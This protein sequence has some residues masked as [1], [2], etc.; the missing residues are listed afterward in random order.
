MKHPTYSSSN[1]SIPF[2]YLAPISHPFSSI[3]N[4]SFMHIAQNLH[5]QDFSYNWCLLRTSFHKSS[6]HARS[7]SFQWKFCSCHYSAWEATWLYCSWLRFELIDWLSDGQRIR[8]LV[9]ARIKSTKKLF[10]V[11]EGEGN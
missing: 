9:R 2:Q 7:F 6:A 1:N 3:R 11:F 5:F 10:F 8:K 4:Y